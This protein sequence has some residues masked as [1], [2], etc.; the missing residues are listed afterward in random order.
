[1]KTPNGPSVL[2][3]DDDPIIRN[4][5]QHYFSK[6]GLHVLTAEDGTAMR[7]VLANNPV[8]LV[9]LDLMLPEEDGLALTRYCRERSDIPIIIL[10]SKSHTIDRIVGL[11]MGADDYIVKPFEPRE[12]LARI[13]TVLRR[14]SRT[15]APVPTV[16]T[17]ATVPSAPTAAEILHFAGWRFDLSQFK[18]SSPQG[19]T[20]RLTKGE[21]SLLL[22]FLR[23]PARVITRDH[24]LALTRNDDSGPY[25]RGID[26][27]VSRLRRKLDDDSTNP[28]FIKTVRGVGYLFAAAVERV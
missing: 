23:N 14:H 15:A 3:V 28:R 10:T 22:V 7:Q 2:V 16:P 17:V 20:I 6:E 12:V 18:L 5:L 27:L 21:A 26:V 19:H 13:R 25:D 1:M 11:E 8:D 4:L 24:L 9:L